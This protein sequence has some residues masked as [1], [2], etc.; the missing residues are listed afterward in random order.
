MS[1]NYWQGELVRLRPLALT[2]V[3]AW[4]AEDVDSEAIRALNAASAE[5]DGSPAAATLPAMSDR[6]PAW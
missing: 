4:L 6:G 2:D 1:A 5:V 3:D